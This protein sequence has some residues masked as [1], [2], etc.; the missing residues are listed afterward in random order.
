MQHPN[1]SQIEATQLRRLNLLFDTL[2]SDNRFYQAKLRS[3]RLPEKFTSIAEF[4]RSVPF[5]TKVE[6]SDDQRRRPPYG[7]NLS[8]PLSC[9]TRY[10]QTSASTG[11]PLRWLDTTEGWGWMLDNW[12]CGVCA[13]P[14]VNP[15]DRVLFT[16]SFGPFLGFWTAFEAAT[17]VIG[18]LC[19]PGGGPQQ[20]R[21]DFRACIGQPGVRALL[22]AYLRSPPGR[23]GR[24]RRGSI[25]EPLRYGRS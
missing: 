20:S 22:Y 11:M 5:T 2:S 15:S 18:C 1:R 13:P 25:W 23:S 16:F 24:K 9:Y 12:E 21:P 14:E 3:A 19:I 7:T 10:S 6:L 8:F 17:S 4:L